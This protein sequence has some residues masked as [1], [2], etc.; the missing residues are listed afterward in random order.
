MFSGAQGMYGGGIN[1]MIFS[2]YGLIPSCTNGSTST[3]YAD[4]IW[5]TNNSTT[6]YYAYT[7]GSGYEGDACGAMI[8]Y[9]SN[10]ATFSSFNIGASISCKPLATT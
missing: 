8:Y 2:P 1:K 4:S 6:K 10:D 9:L 3:Y 7:S 5:Y